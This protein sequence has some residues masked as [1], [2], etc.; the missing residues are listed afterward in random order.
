MSAQASN[1]SRVKSIICI[2]RTPGALKLSRWYRIDSIEMTPAE[3]SASLRSLFDG[4]SMQVSLK[5]V[6]TS[7]QRRLD[8]V[9]R[10]ALSNIAHAS[11]NAVKTQ[12][13][14]QNFQAQC[15][16]YVKRDML[17]RDYHYVHHGLSSG[18]IPAT[19]RA[20]FL[21]AKSQMAVRSKSTALSM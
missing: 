2:R 11:A 1:A 20:E 21:R 12:Q 3:G 5:D 4:S 10:A 14:L 13:V 7:G 15:L 6:A 16:I 19:I 17:N 9:L 18:T 8:A